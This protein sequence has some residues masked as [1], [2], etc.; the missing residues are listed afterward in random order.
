MPIPH[1]VPPGKE[2]GRCRWQ[3]ILAANS[4]L[5]ASPHAGKTAP[6]SLAE[7]RSCR[8]CR[9]PAGF[10][11]AVHEA[12]GN[13]R[14]G[15]QRAAGVGF[16][17]NFRQ[18]PM[19]HSRAGHESFWKAGR[20][21][22]HTNPLKKAARERWP[23]ALHPDRRA[24]RAQADTFAR[25]Q[26][27]RDRPGP[28]PTRACPA[29]PALQARKRAHPGSGSLE[30]I[31]R[32]SQYKVNGVLRRDFRSAGSSRT[33]RRPAASSAARTRPSGF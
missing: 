27:C 9:L 29:S 8:D 1:A 20:A 24:R 19:R 16:P 33:W 5:A 31:M 14:D 25:L 12:L 23:S 6:E 28:P 2:A 7:G 26:C 10:S 18:G 17:G 21:R 15:G 3:G 30:Q 4:R 32:L 22:S 13:S 11:G